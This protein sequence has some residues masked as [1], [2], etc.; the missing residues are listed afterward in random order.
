MASDKGANC[1][2]IVFLFKPIVTSL[3]KNSLIIESN[4]CFIIN[5]NLIYFHVW[6][7]FLFELSIYLIGSMQWTSL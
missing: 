7:Y 1:N 3:V 2:S 6:Y 4:D 5:L